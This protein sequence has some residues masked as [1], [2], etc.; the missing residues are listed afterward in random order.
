MREAFA[1][2]RNARD[3]THQEA[4]MTIIRLITVGAI[5]AL[6]AAAATSVIAGENYSERI[7]TRAGPFGRHCW[8]QWVDTS[9]DANLRSPYSKYVFDGS[10]QL[11]V[12]PVPPGYRGP[13]RKVRQ[14]LCNW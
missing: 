8:I 6:A 7:P 10:V 13:I 2:Q 11:W 1:R 9:A 3:G 4:I 14:E 5:G 12:P